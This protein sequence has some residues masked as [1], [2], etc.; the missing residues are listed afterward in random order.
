MS[1][2]RDINLTCTWYIS[3]EWEHFPELSG[4][5]RS[6]MVSQ[7]TMK[8]GQDVVHR[9][10]T[11]SILPYLLSGRSGKK[12]LRLGFSQDVHLTLLG[13]KVLLRQ[14]SSSSN[15][16]CNCELN[17]LSVSEHLSQTEKQHWY[18]IFFPVAILFLTWTWRVRST[19]ELI[20]QGT[21]GP[22]GPRAVFL[23]FDQPSSPPCLVCILQ[24]RGAHNFL[25]NCCLLVISM[26][27]KCTCMYSQADVRRACC[28]VI[29]IVWSTSWTSMPHWSDA[30]A[31]KN[32]KK[33]KHNNKKLIH[34]TLKPLTVSQRVNVKKII[35]F[36]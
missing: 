21:V 9:A 24:C 13:W 30:T 17:I 22:Y 33:L 18:S 8:E 12:T 15:S 7:T 31:K 26:C 6:G 16:N 10:A 19:I 28:T 29:L 5:S 35:Y 34:C 3:Q 25:P 2:A 14:A 27:R 4:E 11:P 23:G 1:V 20:I 32:I 36:W